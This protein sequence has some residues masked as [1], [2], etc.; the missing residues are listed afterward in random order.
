MAK[1][2]DASARVREVLGDIEL[3]LARAQRMRELGAPERSVDVEVAM[4]RVRWRGIAHAVPRA[5]RWPEA[6]S[7][8]A[9]EIRLA[10][11]AFAS[12]EAQTA[13]CVDALRDAVVMQSTTNEGA[14]AFARSALRQARDRWVEVRKFEAAQSFV[15]PAGVADLAR[16]I[17]SGAAELREAV[18]HI[19]R[20]FERVRQLRA[21]N[22][23]DD[24]IEG[25]FAM[26]RIRWRSVAVEPAA[27]AYEWPPASAELAREARLLPEDFYAAITAD[28]LAIV[29]DVLRDIRILH[30]PENAARPDRDRVHALAV[31][32]AK[33]RW[34]RIFDR[35]EAMLFV[36]P[37]DVIELARDL[38]LVL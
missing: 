38:R 11:V 35:A 22:A 28:T 2:E 7:A 3:G 31:N 5:H 16:T 1:G 14:D 33:Q 30:K 12:F 32:I 8:F 18:E 13:A 9:A 29:V 20:R 15:W 21:L 6:I 37:A 19:E 25:E 27:S 26:A 17:T 23:P 10:P 4:A 24:L 36:W 34:F